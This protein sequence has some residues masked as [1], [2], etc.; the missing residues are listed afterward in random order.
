[1]QKAVFF[2]DTAQFI[3]FLYQGYTRLSVY[4]VFSLHFEKFIDFVCNFCDMLEKLWYLV[5]GC[6][7]YI[8]PRSEITCFFVHR[9]DKGTDQLHIQAG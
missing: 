9:K 3:F 8:E 4:N 1:M 2:H 5:T 7:G 6:S